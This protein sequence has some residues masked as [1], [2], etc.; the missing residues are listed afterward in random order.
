MITARR[1]VKGMICDEGAE[2]AVQEGQVKNTSGK[3]E[4]KSVRPLFLSA[5]SNVD[6]LATDRS[7]MADTRRSVPQAARVCRL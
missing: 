5:V 2:G 7:L 4:P 3:I 1:E 6:S